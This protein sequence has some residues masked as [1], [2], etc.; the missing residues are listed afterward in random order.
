MFYCCL[1]SIICDKIKQQVLLYKIDKTSIID[2]KTAEQF[3]NF[4]F[5]Y[6]C[7][8]T[9][10]GIQEP[11]C[12]S[13]QLSLAF[14]SLSQYCVGSISLIHI[15]IWITLATNVNNVRQGVTY[16]IQV[17]GSRSQCQI[18][19]RT[20]SHCLGQLLSRDC[21]SF[22]CPSISSLECTM[23]VMRYFTSVLQQQITKVTC[24]C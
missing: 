6:P 19:E 9:L 21:S 4:L 20:T 3:L 8:Q 5:I 10:G 7:K 16:K 11:L 12:L 1:G 17:H 18:L 15:W 23:Y 24:W 13:S 2:I 14:G 22:I